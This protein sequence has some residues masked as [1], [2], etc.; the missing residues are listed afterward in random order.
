MYNGV[1]EKAVEA[2]ASYEESLRRFKKKIKMK[3]NQV[4]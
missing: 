3:D 2:E 4:D 1:I